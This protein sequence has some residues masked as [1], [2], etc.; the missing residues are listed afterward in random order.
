MTRI[1]QA[2]LPLVHSAFRMSGYTP[3]Q[4]TLHW[5]TQCFWNYLPWLEIT[6]Y[7]VT[8]V[9]MGSDFQVSKV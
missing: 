8:V 7:V 4:I 9:V 3:S 2:E 6:H 5:L 1:S